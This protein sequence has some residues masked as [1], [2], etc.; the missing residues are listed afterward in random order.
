MYMTVGFDTKKNNYEKIKA[1]TH[2]YD[3][4]VRP[5]LLL[6]SA[7]P[8]Y[9]NIINE[10]YKITKIPALLNTSYNLHGSP[11]SSNFDTIIY[12]FKNSG[13]KYLYVNDYYL[14]KKK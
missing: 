11:L 3:R 14:I 13:L 12:T 4:T 5:Q 2:P 8:Q 6:K 1:G 7:N 10:F 9:Y